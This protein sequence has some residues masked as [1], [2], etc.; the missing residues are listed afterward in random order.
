[1]NKIKISIFA[2]ISMFVFTIFACFNF[3]YCAMRNVFDMYGLT[4]SLYYNYYDSQ[5]N[6][7]YDG[8]LSITYSKSGG[9]WYM[10]MPTINVSTSDNTGA[11]LYAL[12]FNDNVPIDP[13]LNIGLDFKSFSSFINF[14]NISMYVGYNLPINNGSYALDDIRA[15]YSRFTDIVVDTSHITNDIYNIT[16]TNTFTNSVGG[17]INDY[18][19]TI[20]VVSS[21]INDNAIFTNRLYTFDLIDNDYYNTINSINDMSNTITQLQNQIQGLNDTIKNLRNNISKLQNT[22]RNLIE[23]YENQITQ[24]QNQIHG[25]NYQLGIL[26]KG[27]YSFDALFWSIANVPFGVLASTF[28]VNILGI[29]LAGLITGVITSLLLIWLIKKFLR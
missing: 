9:S 1:M 26:Q 6:E 19:N 15:E 7:Q 4:T 22:N 16:S 29:N 28:N 25:L 27:D 3:G 23:Q 17:V 13:T 12:K 18:F 24:L 14:E 10:N 8:P 21:Y 2:L 20:I 5:Q 11:Y